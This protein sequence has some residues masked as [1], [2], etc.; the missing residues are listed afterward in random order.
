MLPTAQTAQ[1]TD[2]DQVLSTIDDPTGQ[3]LAALVTML[4]QGADGNG[5]NIAAAIKALGP[6]MSDTNKLA[7]ILKQQNILLTGTLDGIEPVAAALASNKG[8]TL[9][10]LTEIATKLLETTATNSVALQ[11]TL[12]QLP[13]TLSTARATLA[14]LVGTAAATTPTLRAIRPVTDNLQQISQELLQFADAAD[15]ALASAAPV[16]KKARTLLA[17][18]APVISALKSAGPAVV[19][20]AHSLR[21]IVGDLADNISNVLNFIK[22]WALATN[23]YDGLSHYFR[24]ML[25]VTPLSVTGLVPGA[26]NLGVGGNPSVKPSAPAPPKALLPGLPGLLPGVLGGLLSPKPTSGGGVTGMTPAQEQGGLLALL[27]LGG[28]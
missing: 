7:A 23:G 4:G 20:A 21:P 5:A 10:A 13:S 27:G 8:K 6:A 16:L 22:Y 25:V 3:S 24:G 14:A 9:D 15:P 18:A 11:Q 26:T 2:L 19:S 28:I 17:Q 12:A 1:S